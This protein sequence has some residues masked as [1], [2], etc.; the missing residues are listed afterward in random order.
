MMNCRVVISMVVLCISVFCPI[1]SASIVWNGHI[2]D[3]TPVGT[4]QECQDYAVANGGNLVTINDAAEN[5]FIVS[6]F[7]TISGSQ[8]DFWIGFYS[9]GD[10]ADISTYEWISGE[11]VTYMNWRAY[12]PDYG[13]GTDAYTVINYLKNGSGYWDN[14][15]VSWTRRAIYEVVPEPATVLL[16]GLGGAMLRKRK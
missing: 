15:P 5:E 12:Q 16:L 8:E 4:W 10:Y 9:T 6:A 3:V 14:Y 13:Y 1:V 11:D 7:L 2:Y